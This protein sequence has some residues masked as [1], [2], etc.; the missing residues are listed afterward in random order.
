MFRYLFPYGDVN[1]GS[2][3]VLYGA[4]GVGYNYYYQMRASGFCK[5]VLW[6]D[7]DYEALQTK[8]FP[9]ENPIRIMDM[10]YDVIVVAI[11]SRE[12]ADS[13][14]EYLVGLGVP[15]GK[16]F[17][18]EPVLLD[19]TPYSYTNNDNDIEDKPDESI[20][21]IAP[22]ELVS[23]D[24]MDIV[25]RYLFAKDIVLG[26]DSVRH[27]NLY[28]RFILTV[29][30]ADEP[31]YV[32]APDGMSDYDRKTGLDTFV[33][34]FRILIESMRHEGFLKDDCIPL[35]RNAELLNGSHRL[36]AALALEEEIWVKCLPEERVQD[37]WTID[38]FERSGFPTADRVE[39]MAGFSELYDSCGM[40]LLFGEREL[41]RFI[42]NRV[43]Q[44]IKE[45]GH[46]GLDFRH[47]F[48]A[49]E[50]LLRE[51]YYEDDVCDELIR[52]RLLEGPRV[53]VVV[54]SDENG[55]NNDIIEAVRGRAEEVMTVMGMSRHD[56]YIPDRSRQRHL[57]DVWL[58]H[59][60]IK[61]AGMMLRTASS[62]KLDNGIEC[63]KGRLKESGISFD[64]VCLTDEAVMEILGLREAGNIGV[65]V[66]SEYREKI[67]LP[68]GFC[69][70]DGY[71]G[72]PYKCRSLH[73]V[74]HDMN[75]LNPDLVVQHKH[76][77][78][79]DCFVSE[80]DAVGLINQRRDKDD[81]RLLQLLYD[82]VGC[83]DRGNALRERFDSEIERQHEKNR[84]RLSD[85]S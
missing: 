29:N 3:V 67:I 27:Q 39:L 73:F 11:R 53:C 18:K 24:R 4:G 22:V 72:V 15:C 20:K 46:I 49:F 31:F 44:G 68:D 42:I 38:R 64:C 36:A 71:N 35:N 33:N 63:L 5:A 81:I 84:F 50:S 61:V 13:I 78:L 66:S 58:S 51:T 41:W 12:V 25:V 6:V 85:I 48:I 32:D 74:Y 55:N 83:F 34:D 2:R 75:V 77:R 19:E 9:V 21:R 54:F 62:N 23:S 47:D 16:I 43:L 82:Y 80:T 60:N 28:S 14:R 79:K 56:I 76:D 8:R 10:D 57:M 70:E 45:V 7:R 17:W 59:N 30:G 65:L 40:M 1:K 69:V 52:S 37:Y 26:L